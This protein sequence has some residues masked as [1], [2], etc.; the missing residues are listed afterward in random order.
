[1]FFHVTLHL[2]AK[3]EFQIV[4]SISVFSDNFTWLFTEIAFI[5]A[6]HI[7]WLTNL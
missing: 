5:T 6:S 2:D 3:K 7:T 1:M 4:I